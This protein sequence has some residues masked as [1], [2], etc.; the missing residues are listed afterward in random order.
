MKYP[1]ATCTVWVSKHYYSQTCRD[2]GHALDYF[3]LVIYDI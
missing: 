3:D 2:A 1:L